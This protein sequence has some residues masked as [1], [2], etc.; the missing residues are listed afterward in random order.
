VPGDS[1]VTDAPNTWE[2]RPCLRPMAFPAT[3][4]V[5]LHEWLDGAERSMTS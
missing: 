1:D 4:S 3:F 5:W 2:S